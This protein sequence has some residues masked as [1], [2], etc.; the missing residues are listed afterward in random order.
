MITEELPS[1]CARM[2]CSFFSRMD[3]TKSRAQ[4]TFFSINK[5]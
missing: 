5:N 4:A 1:V 2:I 3:F